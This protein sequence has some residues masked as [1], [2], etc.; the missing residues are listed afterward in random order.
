L[1]CH[2][3]EIDN[4]DMMLE[5][6]RLAMPT[7]VVS[8]HLTEVL[9]REA[10]KSV[11]GVVPNGVESSEYFPCAESV[12]AGTGAIL[13]TSYPKDPVGTMRVMRML[14]SRLPGTPR[15]LFSSARSHYPVG[16][17]AFIRQ[18]TP[19]QARRIYS[20]CKVWFLTSISEGFAMPV[21]EAMACGCVV[22]STRCGGPESIIR[23][24]VN[25]FLVDTGNTG[26]MVHKIVQI[27]KDEALRTHLSANAI[28]TAK[29]FTWSKSAEK[30]EDFLTGI[31]KDKTG[32]EVGRLSHA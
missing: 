30:L 27:H 31:Y 21:L 16:D 32:C 1:F 10:G 11:L 22:V 7:I 29:D 18:P 9:K 24:G 6:W 25:G 12:R 8:P 19:E 5:S 2:G 28:A 20:S 26:A 13:G 23:D 15:Y 3:T 14:E 17:I 4:W